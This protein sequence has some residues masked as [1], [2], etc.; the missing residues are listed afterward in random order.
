MSDKDSGKTVIRFDNRIYRLPAIKK[1][2][3]KY[4]NSFTTDISLE[5]NEIVCALMFI[6][7]TNEERL[8]QDFKK[9][10]L[11]Q[12][13]REQIRNETE[14]IRNLIFALAFSKIGIAGN[15]Q[16]PRD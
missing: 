11:D 16:V 7:P 2:A 15:E 9:E 5:E 6:S 3:Y 10:V 13:L 14:P 1:A 12:D 8:I 4:I